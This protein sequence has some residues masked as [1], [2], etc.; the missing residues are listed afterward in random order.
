MKYIKLKNTILKKLPD[1]DKDDFYLLEGKL[2][3]KNK[4]KSIQVKKLLEDL[5][6]L[7][8]ILTSTINHPHWDNKYESELYFNNIPTGKT[9]V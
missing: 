3:F 7:D 4:D 5:Y 6:S 1:L 2:V 8:I 9:Y